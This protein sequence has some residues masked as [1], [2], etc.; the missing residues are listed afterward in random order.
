MGIDFGYTDESLKRSE[1]AK[2]ADD[3]K[4]VVGFYAEPPEHGAP[5][6]WASGREYDGVLNVSRL[7][8]ELPEL[9][10]TLQQSRWHPDNLEHWYWNRAWVGEVYDDD[11]MREQLRPFLEEKPS[12][13]VLLK[14]LPREAAT[15]ALQSTSPE[16]LITAWDRLDYED[17]KAVCERCPVRPLEN[18][19]CYLRFGNYPGMDAFRMGFL[20]TT[21][22]AFKIDKERLKANPFSFEHLDTERGELPKDKIIEL[23][24]ELEGVEINKKPEEFA[25][26]VFETLLAAA[27]PEE[28]V[29]GE[30][31]D[32][33]YIPFVD[34]FISRYIYREESYSP[35]EAHKLLPY[36]ETLTEVN[37]WAIWDADEGMRRR[38]LIMF[39]DRMGSMIEGLKIADKYGLEMYVSY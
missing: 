26:K 34:E 23:I 22:Y 6:T 9:Y 14:G 18:W 1:Y 21:E 38:P 4:E 10:E 8:E 11:K 37:D 15:E 25:N 24:E 33:T 30:S 36:L 12:G 29:Q 28:E 27:R 7:R 17:R 35:E 5:D 16:D 32:L 13:S 31:I 2:C 20:L 39:R 19:T 3:L